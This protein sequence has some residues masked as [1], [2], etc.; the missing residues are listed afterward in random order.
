MLL[1][2]STVIPIQLGPFLASSDFV[3]PVTGLTPVV[4]VS[5]S[6]AA[7]IPRHDANPPTEDAHGF[8]I[9]ELDAN[10]TNTI[11]ILRVISFAMGTVPV[12]Q[13]YDVRSA[14][15]YD[16]QE[17]ATAQE[18]WEYSNRTLTMSNVSQDT[19]VNGQSPTLLL[20]VVASSFSATIAGVDTSNIDKLWFTI[21]QNPDY[22]DQRSILQIENPGG[23]LYL[24][25]RVAAEPSDASLTVVGSSIIVDIDVAAMSALQPTVQAVWDIK[26]LDNDGIATVLVSGYIQIKS[27]VTLSF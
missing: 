16:D 1:R 9:V 22:S 2:Q 3:T 11:G 19:D 12:V 26:K 5:K 18:V 6:G 20:A 13:D 4:Q 24:N 21:K 15:A 25:A 8:Y 23:L 7:L 14:V 17:G 10:D 27:T